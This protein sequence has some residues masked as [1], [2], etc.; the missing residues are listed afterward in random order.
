[1]D[2]KHTLLDLITISDGCCW[3]VW[4]A[5]AFDWLLGRIFPCAMFHASSSLY[6]K[7]V[8][9]IA[10]I[11]VLRWTNTYGKKERES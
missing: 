1:L 7:I 11:Y 8:L 2:F 9:I 5:L 3:A 10:Y 4:G 6:N